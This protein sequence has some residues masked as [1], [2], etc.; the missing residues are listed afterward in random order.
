MT[1]EILEPLL[2]TC[3]DLA[4]LHSA[5]FERIRAIEGTG[6]AKFDLTQPVSGTSNSLSKIDDRA[7]LLIDLV[8]GLRKIDDF[9]LVPMNHLS[10]LQQSL[11]KITESETELRKALDEIDQNGGPGDIQAENYTLTSMNGA[12]AFA[13][14][15]IGKQID[16]QI[17]TA[18]TH[19]HTASIPLK[20]E[21]YYDF[22]RAMRDASEQIS[23]LRQL[24]DNAETL[25][26]QAEH[27]TA[28]IQNLS[29]QATK[30]REEVDR[31]RSEAAADRKSITDYVG[32]TAERVKAIEASSNQAREL[33][34][35]VEAYET[36]FQKFQALLD[37]REK[38]FADNK[39]KLEDLI[40]RSTIFDEQIERRSEASEKM[41]EGATVA[42]LAGSFGKKRNEL[43]TELDKSRN[44]FYFAIAVLF[45]SVLPLMLYVFGIGV[46][47]EERSIGEFLGQAL[48]RL[49]LLLPAAWLTTFAAVRH[50]ALFRLKEHYEFK[51]SIAM[52]VE[53]FKQQ[54]EE[55]E[56][57]IAAATFFELTFNPADR[58]DK[59]T[60]EHRA[61][62]PI[63]AY[64]LEK[65]NKSG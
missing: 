54:A 47:V 46:A 10:S 22:T 52:S 29:E 58:L 7:I 62:N 33:Q 1:D 42:G 60:L 12:A 31:L 39:A 18:L 23:Y 43:A 3:E 32:E 20:G 21:S 45:I 2:V 57:Q 44:A 37:E 59:K 30:S 40:E 34:T 55:H 48:A 5:N 50:A 53:G 26:R 16:N 35:S 9:R 49:I 56:Q 63:M 13:L 15:K 6:G 64:L 11:V 36:Q 8:F 25:R 61:P 65:L 24:G 17:D 41:L 19:F 51:Q 14:G 38:T 4:A 27:Q 28:Q